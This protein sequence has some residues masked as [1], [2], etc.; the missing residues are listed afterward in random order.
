MLCM[1]AEDLGQSVRDD[2]RYC[3][4][5]SVICGFIVRR[6]LTYGFT[7]RRSLTYDFLCSP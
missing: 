6:S 7:V 4:M 5:W 3:F 2:N 1:T